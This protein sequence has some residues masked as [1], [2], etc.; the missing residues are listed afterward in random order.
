MFCFIISRKV[1]MQLKCKKRLA[2]CMEKGLCLIKGAQSGLRNF[3]VPLTLWPNNPLL[4]GCLRHWKLFS[5]APGLYTL[6]A[7]SGREQHTQHIQINTVIGEN[8]TCVF[9][10]TDKKM[11]YTFWPTQY[12][13]CS[14][15][16]RKNKGKK[17]TLLKNVLDKSIIIIN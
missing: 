6:E 5:S 15:T 4:W 10:F 16:L 3:L 11:E 14:H 1:K 12:V 9:Y 7:N 17:L 13:L 8:E 2:Q